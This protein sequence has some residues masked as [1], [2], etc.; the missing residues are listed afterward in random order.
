[1][2]EGELLRTEQKNRTIIL[3]EIHTTPGRMS[4]SQRHEKDHSV[5]RK[6]KKRT[7][8]LSSTS[9]IQMST[10]LYNFIAEHIINSIGITKEFHISLSA[11]EAHVAVDNDPFTCR[12]AQY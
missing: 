12:R 9:L 1:M 2:E 7:F 10:S 3:L 11:V 4:N 6:G 5:I 8:E